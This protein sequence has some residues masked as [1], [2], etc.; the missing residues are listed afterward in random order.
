MNLQKLI[1]NLIQIIVI[2]YLLVTTKR[3]ARWL[4]WPLFVLTSVL[5]SPWILII[6]IL[7][8]ELIIFDFILGINVELIKIN[9]FVIPIWV[10]T[11][12]LTTPAIYNAITLI[13]EEWDGKPTI[14]SA[15]G[16][17]FGFLWGVAATIFVLYRLGFFESL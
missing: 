4:F 3:K 9:W 16:K 12:I 6:I 8:I 15:T 10:L 1:K 7:L 13:E 5:L 2:S 14:I 17:F 11:Y